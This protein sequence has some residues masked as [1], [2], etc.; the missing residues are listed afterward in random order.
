[1]EKIIRNVAGSRARADHRERSP[2]RVDSSAPTRGLAAGVMNSGDPKGII[3]G[4]AFASCAR[5]AT[6]IYHMDG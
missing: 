2:L 3:S 1:M 5:L 4:T 6:V